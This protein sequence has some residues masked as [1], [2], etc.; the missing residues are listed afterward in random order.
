VISENRFET[1]QDYVQARANEL[2]R[3]TFEDVVSLPEMSEEQ[4][5]FNGHRAIVMTSHQSKPDGSHWVIFEAYEQEGQ[6]S[7]SWLAASGVAFTPQA[8]RKLT[9]RELVR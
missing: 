7:D 5:L 3:L 1:I 8:H 4:I 9:D 6:W 2:N